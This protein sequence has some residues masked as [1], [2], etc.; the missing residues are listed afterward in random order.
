MILSPKPAIASRISPGVAPK[1]ILSQK[2]A[3]ASRISP[4]SDTIAKTSDSIT[5]SWFIRFYKQSL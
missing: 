4:E 1:V 5:D 2:P 3:I